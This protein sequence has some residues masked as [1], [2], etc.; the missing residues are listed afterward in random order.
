MEQDI[1][2]MAIL[3]KTV[4]AVESITKRTLQPMVLI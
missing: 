1:K 4:Q 2:T 3:M